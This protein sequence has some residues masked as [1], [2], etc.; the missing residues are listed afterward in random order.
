MPANA[1][2][3]LVIHPD[4]PAT[5]AAIAARLLTAVLDAQAARGEATIVLTGGTLGIASL[6]AVADS[7][8]VGAVDWSRV[9]IYWGDERFVAADSADRNAVAAEVLLGVL[10]AHGLDRGRVH[11]MGSA[12]GF[13]TPEDAAAAYAQVLVDEADAEGTEGALPIFDVLML[14]MGPDSHVA[15]LFPDHAGA[16]TTG[17]TVIGVHDSPKPPPLRVS[18]S[19]EAINTARALWLVVAGADKAPAAGIVLGA[20]PVTRER[21]PASGVS[22]TGGTWW[23]MDAAAAELI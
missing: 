12:D 15:S 9:N 1:K 19:F 10:D 3:H 23:L 5:A 4:L 17:A 14:G 6:K 16:A 22:G 11:P 2:R 21:V 18:L 7:P 13:A 8:A 20:D